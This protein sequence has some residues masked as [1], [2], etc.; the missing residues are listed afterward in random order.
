MPDIHKDRAVLLD[1][2]GL[3]M[4]FPIYKGLLRKTA[5]LWTV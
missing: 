4:H 3:K 5:G 2:R 1:V